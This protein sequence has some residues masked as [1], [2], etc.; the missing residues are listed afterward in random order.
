MKN[1]PKLLHTAWEMGKNDVT[2]KLFEMWVKEVM[3]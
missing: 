3:K 1:I 2:E